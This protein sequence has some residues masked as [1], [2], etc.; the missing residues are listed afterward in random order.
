MRRST[1]SEDLKI[2]SLWKLRVF[3]F[4]TFVIRRKRFQRHPFISWTIS[5][6]K[7]H[8]II[9][10]QYILNYARVLIC[11]YLED[12]RIYNFTINNILLFLSYKTN[13]F[14]VAVDLQSNRSQKTSKCDENITNKLGCASCVNFFCSYHILTSSVIHYWTDTRQHGI[15]LFFRRSSWEIVRISAPITDEYWQL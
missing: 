1:E 6:D 2:D 7:P 13:G 14:H 12:R 4:P 15:N 5:Q 9:I 8:N 11:C 3:P 10:I